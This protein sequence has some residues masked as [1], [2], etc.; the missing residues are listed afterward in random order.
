MFESSAYKGETVVL[1]PYVNPPP[2]PPQGLSSVAYDAT[3][4]DNGPQDF[5]RRVP[6]PKG[7][8]CLDED[9][10]KNVV[11]GTQLTFAIQDLNNA[12]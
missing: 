4:Q 12:R 1:I 7:A 5:L 10:P 11:P 9:N 2:L 8:L 6:C 3:C